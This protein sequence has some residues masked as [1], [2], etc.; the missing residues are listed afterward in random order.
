MRSDCLRA[1]FADEGIRLSVICPV[2]ISTPIAGRAVH[3]GVDRSMSVAGGNPP[4]RVRRAPP[5][6]RPP[7]H[8]GRPGER[9]GENRICAFRYFAVAVAGNR[10]HYG[11]R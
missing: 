8:G 6:C 3:H 2:F 7:E 5:V 9:R 1:E 11:F 4:K 10:P